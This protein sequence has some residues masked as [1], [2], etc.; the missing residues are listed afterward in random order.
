MPNHIGFVGS[1]ILLSSFVEPILTDFLRKVMGYWL[2]AGNGYSTRRPST[3]VSLRICWL[4]GPCVMYY[5][6]YRQKVW[7]LHPLM[8]V[9]IHWSSGLKELRQCYT[10]TIGQILIGWFF[11][12]NRHAKIGWQGDIK[13]FTIKIVRW[14]KSCVDLS[15]FKTIIG[16][17]L[18]DIL[19]H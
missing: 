16:R 13:L 15:Y 17:V 9:P 10:L 4:G 11:D 7:V 18:V 5:W 2:V 6:K 14:W 3:D 19:N 1:S 8:V 12:N